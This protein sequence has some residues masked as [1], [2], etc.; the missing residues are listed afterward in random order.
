[1]STQCVDYYFEQKKYKF[2]LGI[3]LQVS[4]FGFLRT[5]GQLFT[6]VTEVK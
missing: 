1:M 2:I 3:T 6:K 4:S 5:P